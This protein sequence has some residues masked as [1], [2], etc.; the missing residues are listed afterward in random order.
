VVERARVLAGT[1]L[2]IKCASLG[3]FAGLS[4]W[5]CRLASSRPHWTPPAIRYLHGEP[6]RQGIPKIPLGQLPQMREVAEIVEFPGI[7]VV[8]EHLNL[9]T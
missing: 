1:G 4:Q 5:R 3:A 9:S 6:S 2:R 7:G 8:A